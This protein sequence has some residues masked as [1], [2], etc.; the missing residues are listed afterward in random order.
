MTARIVRVLFTAVFM[1]ALGGY[2]H[3][4]VDAQRPPYGAPA[5]SSSGAPRL[6][7]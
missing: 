3:A 4:C 7:Y 2:A 5:G 1:I 6:Y